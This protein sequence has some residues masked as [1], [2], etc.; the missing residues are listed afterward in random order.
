MSDNPFDG[1]PKPPPEGGSLCRVCQ[2]NR[3]RAGICPT[4]AEAIDLEH[5]RRD[6][7]RQLR[8]AIESIPRRA[9]GMVFGLE[10]EPM[11]GENGSPKGHDPALAELIGQLLNVRNF[12]SPEAFEAA[13]EVAS[14][15]T[16]LV[17]RGPTGT[18]K[19][20][21]GVA[22]LNRV[23]RAALDLEPRALKAGS[24]GAVAR[25]LLEQGSNARFASAY[26]L[27][28]A[29]AESPLGR[30]EAPAIARAVEASVLLLDD[31]GVEMVRSSAVP[32]VLV[33][34]AAAEKPTI[35]TT[36]LDI[37]GIEQKYREWDGS[38]LARR[39]YEKGVATVIQT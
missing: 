15:P 5:A 39:L 7:R 9:R 23:I 6:L 16:F 3:C 10:D 4:C 14:L 11:L 30:G 13:R 21:L 8:P 18:G 24:A 31:V 35:I 2:R 38:G 1:V 17:F 33:E 19:T 34:R 27:A 32:E 28:K 22:V 29:R 25:G 37:D 36:K 20:S 12:T 26:F